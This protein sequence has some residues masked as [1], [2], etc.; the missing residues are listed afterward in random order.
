MIIELLRESTFETRAQD[1]HGSVMVRV[2]SRSQVTD[3]STSHLL[4]DLA[5]NV[6]PAAGT[7]PLAQASR[8]RQLSSS[9]P[10]ALKGSSTCPLDARW[11]SAMAAAPDPSVPQNPALLL[12][13]YLPAHSRGGKQG[14]NP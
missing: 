3:P 13:G 14:T 6:S 5:I 7:Q 1:A 8:E 9:I 4:L 2:W 10:V 12:V 11:A